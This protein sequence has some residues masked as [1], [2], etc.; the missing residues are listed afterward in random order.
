MNLLPPPLFGC[1]HR[2]NCD[3]CSG[4]ANSH[5]EVLAENLAG[6]TLVATV[7][8]SLEGKEVAE[9]A[10]AKD[11]TKRFALANDPPRPD[12]ILFRDRKM[13]RYE[14]NLA[15]EDLQRFALTEFAV[16]DGQ[17]VPKPRTFF[18]KFIATFK[19]YFVEQGRNV[20]L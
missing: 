2:R 12:V 18:D 6:A 19:S 17:D 8:V 16:L 20:E 14:G 13:F 5:L 4:L 11:L 1:V 10:A 3:E 7:D 15:V 9:Q